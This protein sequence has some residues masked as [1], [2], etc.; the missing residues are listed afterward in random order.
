MPSAIAKTP[1]TAPL[2]HAHQDAAESD[3]GKL[4]LGQRIVLG[5]L[6]YYKVCISPVLPSACKFYPTCSMY[7]K[8]AVRMHGVKRGSWMALKRLGRCHPFTR[9]GFDPVPD[10]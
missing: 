3:A 6:T 1:S 9:G 4:T 10:A 5:L 7:A 8:E 2:G